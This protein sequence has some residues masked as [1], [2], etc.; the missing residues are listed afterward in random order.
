ML[1]FSLANS[2][3]L[4]RDGEASSARETQ[5]ANFYP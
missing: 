3:L 4:L 1:L 2:E 5:F